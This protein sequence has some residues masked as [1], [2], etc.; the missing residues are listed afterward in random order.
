MNMNMNMR[1]EYDIRLK[2]L[3]DNYSA[4][5]FVIKNAKAEVAKNMLAEGIDIAVISR[6][7]GL[8]VAQI[9]EL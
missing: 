3:R 4:D 6:V 1:T 9:K 2:T 7:T 5:Q 8:T